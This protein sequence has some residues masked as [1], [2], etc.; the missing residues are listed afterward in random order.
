MRWSRPTAPPAWPNPRSRAGAH[1]PPTIA[2]RLAAATQ[3]LRATSDT[4]RLDAEY[5]LAHVLGC[6]RGALLARLHTAPEAPGFEACLARRAAHEPVA[7]ILG[8][9]GFHAIEVTCRAPV[10]VPRPETELLADLAVAHLQTTSRV[11]TAPPRLLDLCTGTGCVALAVAHALPRA[12][13]VATD[14]RPA[15]VRLARENAGRLAPG[16]PVYAGDLFAALPP[17]SRPFHAI[18][19]NPPYVCAGAWAQLAPTIRHYEDAAALLAG[20]DGLALVR[21]LVPEARRWLAPGGLLA[22]EIDDA[23]AHAVTTLFGA[24]GYAAPRIA[25]DLAGKNR[26]VWGKKA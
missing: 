8:H 15:A 20:A 26:V 21:R 3:S 9:W 5:L 18:T 11:S 14:A 10:L 1:M 17:T 19:A 25:R 7:Y 2:Q 16:V 12:H 24:A 22:I 4:P 23:Q 13:I 6:S